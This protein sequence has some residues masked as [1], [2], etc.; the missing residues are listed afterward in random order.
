MNQFEVVKLTELARKHTKPVAFGTLCVEPLLRSGM[1]D[2]IAND[3]ENYY[4]LRGV[5]D[6]GYA[7]DY[8]VTSG[9]CRTISD[10]LESFSFNRG[11]AAKRNILDNGTGMVYTRGTNSPYVHIRMSSGD[12]AVECKVLVLEMVHEPFRDYV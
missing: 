12:L 4:V 5:S 6:S 11:E 10:A 9:M 7:I 1:I 3:D 8:S 2:T